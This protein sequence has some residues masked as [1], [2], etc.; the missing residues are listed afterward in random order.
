MAQTVFNR[1]EKKF[2]L[3][4]EQYDA[5]WQDLVQ[6][7]EVDAFAW[8]TICNLYYDTPTDA[9]IRASIEKPAYKEKLRLRSYGVPAENEKVYLEIKKKY[10]GIV[11]KRRIELSLQEA[12]AYL[13]EGKRLEKE[14]QILREL[15][16]FLSFYD[17][18]AKAYIA[19]ERVA[20]FGKEDAQF[21]VTFDTNV[22]GR[23]EHLRL[24]DGSAG[25]YILPPGN[26]IMEVKITNATPLWFVKLLN[27]HG[28]VGSSFS[29]YGTFYKKQI[30]EQKKKKVEKTDET[31]YIVSEERT[32]E[33]A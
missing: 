32:E 8:H 18:S 22:R 21:R 5:I 9:L 11:N 20:L 10:D 29:K 26:Y 1:V 19:Y 23:R 31:S 12:Y 14:C 6:Y 7:M 2:I 17:L 13:N 4:S 16:Y 25:D 33:T 30:M 3:T 24:E 27:K 15:D 28:I